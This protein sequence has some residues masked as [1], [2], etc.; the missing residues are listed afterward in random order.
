MKYIT[1]YSTLFSF[2]QEGEQK[3]IKKE[4]KLA[5]KEKK[6]VFAQKD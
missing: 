3:N 5:G 6:W 1:H 4:K 2:C